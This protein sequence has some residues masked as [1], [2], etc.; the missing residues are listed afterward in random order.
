MQ[1]NTKII[2]TLIKLLLYYN[3]IINSNK[4]PC[5]F[6]IAYKKTINIVFSC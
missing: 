6:P 2:Y 4:K 5:N 1:L 3:S